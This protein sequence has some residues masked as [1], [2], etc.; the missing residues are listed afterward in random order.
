MAGAGPTRRQLQ[1]AATQ[2]QLLAAARDVFEVKGYAGTT[3]G[4]I[5]AAASTAH[6]TFYL[7]F[8]NKEDVFASVMAAATA[9]LYDQAGTKATG[10]ARDAVESRIRGFLEVF[11]R[12]RGLWR[13][14]L[15]GSL[16]NPAIE[17]MWLDI[18]QRFI[19]RTERNL[20]WLADAGRIRPVH[21]RVAANAL[22]AMVEWAAMTQFVLGAR[23]VA[24]ES[25]DDCVRT[26]TD[27]WYHAVF[28]DPQVPSADL[29]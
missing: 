15:E 5:T 10:E 4:A 1:A 29:R 26:L 23:P 12:H 2:E 18:R 3:V 6:G 24:E 17:S 14:L 27:L 19:D 7:H 20:R 22:G 11:V 21:P 13:C 16:T 25:F 28:A 8:R 9:E